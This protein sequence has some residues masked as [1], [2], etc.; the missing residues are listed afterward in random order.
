MNDLI[1]DIE[2][3]EK[4]KNLLWEKDLSNGFS[5]NK[6]GTHIQ[7]MINEKQK[8]L[9]EFEIQNMS[10]EQYAEH[11]KGRGFNG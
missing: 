9:T 3:L 11:M 6:I 7:S 4:L 2:S 10:F 5:R 1:H 8:Q